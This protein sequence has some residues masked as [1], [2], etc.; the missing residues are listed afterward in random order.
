MDCEVCQKETA[1]GDSY[2]VRYGFERREYVSYKREAVY[3]SIAGTRKVWICDNCLNHYISRQALFSGLG[4]L[5][6]MG[7]LGLVNFLS[8]KPLAEQI[9]PVVLGII[10]GAFLFLVIS[11]RRRKSK[12]RLQMGDVYAMRL[13]KPELRRQG[14]RSFYTR[15]D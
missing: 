7:S 15:Q 1:A 6:L 9:S 5:L 14:Y 13:I 4:M 3:R 8:A 10:G 11:S 2:I 12:G